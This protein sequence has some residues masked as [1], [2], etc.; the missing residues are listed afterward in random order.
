MSDGKGAA[1]GAVDTRE[2]AD[3]EQVTWLAVGLAES[4]G[5]LI[6]EKDLAGEVVA[7]AMARA[8]AMVL[9]RHTPIPERNA[10]EQKLVLAAII[11]QA[12]A[13]YESTVTEVQIGEPQG[14][15]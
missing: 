14:S 9:A 10:Q 2:I 13:A 8:A 11:K 1:G 15:A 6:E 4:A 7:V 12:M 3:A 5:S